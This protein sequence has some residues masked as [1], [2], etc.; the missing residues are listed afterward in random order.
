MA[1]PKTSRDPRGLGRVAV[2]RDE[3]AKNR[4]PRM[5][6]SIAFAG[7]REQ[8]GGARISGKIG[9]VSGELRYQHHGRA[10]S[11]G[12]DIN[13]G[14]KR[15]T[16]VAVDGGESAGA[17]GAQAFFGDGDSIEIL[18]RACGFRQPARHDSR[19]KRVI[20]CVRHRFPDFRNI[21]QII[22]SADKSRPPSIAT[23][24]PV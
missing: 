16:G 5:G 17:G 24:S 20:F 7:G 10:V 12:R 6:E 3:S 21:G 15:V 11:V 22:G 4:Q 9:G 8:H 19:Q 2:N 23:F 14:R 13:E 1:R 18:T